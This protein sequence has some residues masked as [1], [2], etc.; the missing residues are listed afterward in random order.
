MRPSAD[1]CDSLTRGWQLAP[2]VGY[3]SK[4]FHVGRE[5]SVAL[6]GHS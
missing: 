4:F 6:I 1:G 2:R 5:S 3:R